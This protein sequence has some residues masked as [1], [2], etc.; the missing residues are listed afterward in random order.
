MRLTL[1][2]DKLTFDGPVSTPTSYLS[3]SKLHWNSVISTLGSKYLVV[4]IKNFYLNN[5][6]VKNKYYKIAISL[7][8]K[9]VIDEYNTMAKQINGFIYVRLENGIYGLVQA[10]I[11]AHMALKEHL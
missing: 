1:G 2:G 5:E 10:G 4:D 8:S 9:E 3:T 6:M 11:I 7:I